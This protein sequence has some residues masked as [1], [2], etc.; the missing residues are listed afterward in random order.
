MSFEL[1][2]RPPRKPSR[3]WIALLAAAVLVG[4]ILWYW[5]AR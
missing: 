1:T 2:P 5:L 4:A 3:G